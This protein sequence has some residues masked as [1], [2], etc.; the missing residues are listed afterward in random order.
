MTMLLGRL[1]I[2]VKLLIAQII[3]FGLLV[4]LLQKFLYQ[5]L[6]KHIE[7]EE[8]ALKAGE[9]EEES[10]Q[11][12]EKHIAQEKSQAEKD[13]QQKAREIIS[14]AEDVAEKIREKTRQETRLEKQKL[15]EQIQ[16]RL[17]EIDNGHNEK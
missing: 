4:W 14:T 8:A 3:N 13:A 1:G 12:E 2:D 5:P 6:V 15:I 11:D 9:K 17:K 7:K 16:A 10:L